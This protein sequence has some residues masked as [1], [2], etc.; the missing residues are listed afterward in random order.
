MP[1]LYYMVTLGLR[2]RNPLNGNR[3]HWAVQAKRRRE[4]R[5]AVALSWQAA[6]MPRGITWAEGEAPPVRVRI[7]RLG[8]G[9]MDD[10]GLAASAKAV[11]DQVAEELGINDKLRVW[12]YAQE[13]SKTYGVRIEVW[14]DLD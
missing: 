13:R 7:T 4:Q 2:L 12:S 14:L 5:R 10:D 11:R 9:M 3:E 1:P 6:A 8:P